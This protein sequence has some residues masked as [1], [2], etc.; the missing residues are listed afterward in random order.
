MIRN[1]DNVIITYTGTFS[2][3]IIPIL[4]LYK[5]CKI[6]YTIH[7]HG[8]GMKKWKHSILQR[9][10]FKNAYS[11]IGVSDEI[12]KEYESRSGVDIK[13]LPPLLPFIKSKKQNIE[14]MNFK[15]IILFVGTLKPLKAPNIL[16]NA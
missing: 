2:S 9:L 10:F 15:K 12:V 5:L 13:Y 6:N 11:V 8:G 4:F 14:F 16:L 3:N 7:I 1:V